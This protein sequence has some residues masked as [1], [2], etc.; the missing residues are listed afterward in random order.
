MD[1]LKL[2]NINKILL[3]S[4]LVLLGWFLLDIL[5]NLGNNDL[6]LI[7]LVNTEEPESEKKEELQQLLDFNQYAK[8][9]NRR[10]LFKGSSV[11]D[12]NAGSVISSATA[13]LFSDFQLLGIVSGAKPQAIIQ[14]KR[15]GSTYFLYKGQSQDNLIAED[16]LS[17]K[18]RLNYSGEIFE[19]FL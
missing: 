8:E 13:T 6:E 12:G 3:L 2:H 11:Q 4:F 18:V 14:N 15:T 5:L 17:N 1:N 7:G 16:I 9:I 10:Q 19:L